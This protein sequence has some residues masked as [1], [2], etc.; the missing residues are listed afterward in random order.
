MQSLLDVAEKLEAEVAMRK[1]ASVVMRK[2]ASAVVH[3]D[4]VMDATVS[5]MGAAKLKDV[6]MRYT[7]KN[8]DEVPLLRERIHSKAYHDDE[9]RC[10][11]LGYGRRLV[12]DNATCLGTE[13]GLPLGTSCRGG[14]CRLPLAES[15]RLFDA[16]HAL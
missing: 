6:I 16:H 5:V 1:P 15:G 10:D 13:K 7:P 2:P 12:T 9:R 4:S 11:K 3:A 8:R 14:M